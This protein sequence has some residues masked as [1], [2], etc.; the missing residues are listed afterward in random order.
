MAIADALADDFLAHAIDLA[1]FEE[2]ERQKLLRVFQELERTLIRELQTVDPPGPQSVIWQRRRAEALLAHVRTVIADHYRLG[3]ST[4]RSDLRQ[5]A[6][7]EVA[8][9]TQT[10]NA[11]VGTSVLTVGVSEPTLKA[12][13]DDLVIQGAPAQ[14]WWSR[15]AGTL[16][17]RYGDTI[18]QGLVRGDSV[19]TM[20]RVLRGSREAGFRDG[21]LSGSRRDIEAL[22]R[23]SV[24]SV[25]AASRQAVFEQNTDVISGME[26]ISALDPRVCQ[27]CAPLSGEQW[28]LEGR[29][30][31]GTELAYPGPPP[32]H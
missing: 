5:L 4:L 28:T 26:W 2:A 7:T 25:T 9:T 3:A 1:R 22:V 17:R 6:S 27:Y 21:V 14:E 8:F 18:R 23:T 30:L 15:Q 32:R 12:M 16:L 24:Q 29:K 10:V 11:T 31:P 20:V 13:L 19:S